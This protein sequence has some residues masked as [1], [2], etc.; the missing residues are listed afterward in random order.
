[1]KFL[2]YLAVELK[3]NTFI[4]DVSVLS[5]SDVFRGYRSKTLVENGLTQSIINIIVSFLRPEKSDNKQK[6]FCKSFM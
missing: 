2:L 1:M 3:E 6:I 4:L 5:F